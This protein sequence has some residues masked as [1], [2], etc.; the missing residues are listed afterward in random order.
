MNSEVFITCAVTGAGENVN[1]SNKVP[2]SP[3][4]IANDAIAAA[5]AGAAIAHIHVRD[6]KT[7]IGSRDVSLYRE[8]V[9][10]IRAS[11]VDVIVNLTAGMGGDLVFGKD[12]PLDFGLES[13]LVSQA[14]R[15]EHVDAL[16]PEICTLD[17][18]SY[19]VGRG[20]LVYISTNDMVEEGARRIRKMGVKPELELFELG[21]AGF[22][23]DL[24]EEDAFDQP[25]MAQI[26][27][28]VP[29]AAPATPEALAAMKSLLPSSRVVW[30]AFG[31]GRMQMPMVAQAVCS[32]GHVRV[33]LEDNIYLS[34]G[35]LASNVDL[36]ERART[37]IENLG[38][39]ILTPAETRM[40]LGLQ[41]QRSAVAAAL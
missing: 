26:C 30:S 10:R 38:A 34:K 31:V 28:G 1:R 14:V 3:E 39:R 22:V 17:C 7:G 4:Q 2:V 16:R 6:P 24:I 27:L 36:V 15:L 19:N 40:K 37:I 32:G 41:R 13:D 29:G 20:S 25:I 12:N 5:R 11:D 35:K 23:R 33:G 8:V 18:G 21:H 9:E